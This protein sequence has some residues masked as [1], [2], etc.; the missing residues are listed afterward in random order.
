ML[1][2]GLQGLQGQRILVPSRRVDRPDEG[3]LGVRWERFLG[4]A[5]TS[6][7][8]YAPRLNTETH[9]PVLVDLFCGVGGLSLGFEQAGFQVALAVDIELINVKAYSRNFPKASV[10][11]LDLQAASGFDLL[12]L[13]DLQF[14]DVDVVVGGPPCQGFSM[15]GARRVDDPRNKLIFDFL[16]LSAE[17]G[18]PYFVME[19]VP[20]LKRGKMG[21]IFETWKKEAEQFEY[22]IVDPVWE[23]NARDFGVPQSRTRC[24][25]V[26][27]RRDYPVP[28]V[29]QADIWCGDE[30]QLNLKPAVKDAIDDLPDPQKY[31]RLLSSDRVFAEF[32][33]PSVYARYLRGENTDRC[34]MSDARECE[35][36][37]LTCSK[38]T[39]HFESSKKRFR[40]TKPGSTE[41]ISRFQKL[42]PNG[43][44]PTLRAGT[45]VEEGSHTAARPIHPRKA[46][47]ITVR[48]AAR[49]QSFPDWFEFDPTIW[50]G[51]RQVGNS[52]PPNL[53]RAVG[54]SIAPLLNNIDDFNAS[55]KPL[56]DLP[57]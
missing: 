31:K 45:G 27:Y 54:K 34:D 50:H 11:Q 8:Q 24:F 23:L 5:T 42:D 4:V 35:S 9:K 49:L 32:G 12:E 51:F 26:G 20:G 52:V 46:R 47:C 7:L 28:K 14:G 57:A 15:I 6:M 40:K 33:E 16:R 17:I 41:P 37:T 13:S 22:S 21:A 55:Q 48:E 18:A 3:R 53:A 30:C 10:A 36:N 1:R 2:H 39:V 44:A 43:L 25:V 29:P 38:R 19:N 56:G